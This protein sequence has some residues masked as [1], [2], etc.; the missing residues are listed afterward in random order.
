MTTKI[1]FLKESY[2]KKEIY[3]T[4]SRVVKMT[5]FLLNPYDADLDLSDKDD[6][7]LFQEGSKGIKS[8]NK[9]EC[10]LFDG[11]KANFN[12]FSKIIGK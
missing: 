11:K 5:T 4:V 12:K 2:F 10:I 1:N 6:R 3:P 8:T 9:D 7:K